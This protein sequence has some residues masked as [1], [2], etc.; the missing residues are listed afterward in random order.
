SFV[1]F[2]I[3]VIAEWQR[4]TGRDVIVALSVSKD[5]Q[6]AI[7]EDPQRAEYVDVIDIRYWCYAAG[8]ALYAPHGGGNLAPRQH[9]R[10]TQLKLGGAAEIV[11]AVKEYRQLFPDKAVTYFAEQY[12]PSRQDG[13]AVLAG[14]GSLAS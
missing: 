3:D 11:R 7:L 14:G 12:C 2:W 1:Q 9:L 5:V 4:E 6:D 8:G 13:W 10:Q